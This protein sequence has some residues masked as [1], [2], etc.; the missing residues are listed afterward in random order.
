MSAEDKP[1]QPLDPETLATAIASALQ[2]YS[3]PPPTDVGSAD[4]RP[5][6]DQESVPRFDPTQGKETAGKIRQWARRSSH[7]LAAPINLAFTLVGV[8]P[9]VGY[10]WVELDQA[11]AR[12]EVAR[13]QAGAV[14]ARAETLNQKGV[15][16][17]RQLREVARRTQT[18]LQALYSELQSIRQNNADLRAKLRALESSDE[19]G[20]VG[21][22]IIDFNL[23]GGGDALVPEWPRGSDLGASVYT[24][25]PAILSTPAVKGDRAE[26]EVATPPSA[27]EELPEGLRIP[28]PEKVY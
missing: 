26:E 2:S 7:P 19:E 23:L 1:P 25:D 10:M 21:R 28:E 20:G 18:A 3:P 9:I 8:L 11:M 22:G 4:S 13:D 12:A 17:D 16:S 15:I 6:Q 14:E 27:A 24:Y 5:A